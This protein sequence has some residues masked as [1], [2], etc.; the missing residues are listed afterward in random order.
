MTLLSGRTQSPTFG[1]GGTEPYAAALQNESAVLYLHGS[2]AQSPT[3]APMDAG[4]WSAGADATDLDV[5]T[6]AAGPVLDIG[7]GPGRMVRAAMDLGL[8]AL[9]VDVSPTAVRI[10]TAAGLTVLNRS[11]FASMPLEGGWG[12][13]LLLDGNIGIGGDAGA[14]LARCA[15]LLAED[16]ALV[17]E[18][19]QEPDRDHAFEGTLEDGQGRRSGAFPWAEIG[20][21]PLRARAEKA[22][23]RV[24]QDW[25]R[26]G[27]WFARLVRR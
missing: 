8:S 6:G 14:L 13:A 11:V 10:A 9:G 24:D 19:S 16:G 3:A 5:L 22:G 4:R 1:A 7:C 25:I 2:T 23:L 27:R 12:T 20:I 18:V 17:V 21:V 26:D 15:E